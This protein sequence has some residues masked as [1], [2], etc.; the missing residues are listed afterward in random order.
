MG[1]TPGSTGPGA[2]RA[3]DE[4]VGDVVAVRAEIA[5]LQARE[6]E[7]LATAVDLVI[8]RTA[9]RRSEQRRYGNDLALREVCAELGAAMRVSERTV[10]LRMGDAS[11][12]V[13]SFPDTLEAW[14]AG[15]IDHRHV[16]VIR[17]AGATIDDP[18]ARTRYEQLALAAAEIETAGRLRP[19]VRVIADRVDPD[20]SEGRRQ[21]A[22]STRQVRVIDLDDGLA[23]LIADLPAALAYAIL[24]RLTQMGRHMHESPDPIEGAVQCGG[25]GCPAADGCGSESCEADG[26]PGADHE[27][28]TVVRTGPGEKRN[29]STPSDEDPR[30]DDSAEDAGDARDAEDA[31]DA[32][33]AGDASDAGDA[34]DA[35]DAGDAF[36]VE[37]ADAS[38]LANGDGSAGVPGPGLVEDST[39]DEAVADPRTMDQLRADILADLLL[40]AAPTA[41]GTK[42]G[43]AA[44]AAHVQ[45]SVP[46]L[47]AAGRGDEPALLAGYGPIDVETARRLAGGA[48]GWDRVMFHPHTGAP[49]AVDRYRRSAEL[50]RFLRARDERCR[51]PGCRQPV[52]RCDVDHTIDAAHGGGTS[53]CNLAHLC[54]RHHILKHGSEWTVRQLGGGVLEWRSPTGRRYLDKP[55]GTVRFVPDLTFDGDPPPF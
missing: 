47:T 41:H 43:L 15:R 34:G 50:D 37:A 32:G 10:Q 53:E 3:L 2:W 26:C 30:R 6:A 31:G 36:G 39:P 38:P 11:A 5:A 46:V 18:A 14:R 28:A 40:S 9:E 49:L 7:L 17:D 52:W 22:Q 19:L 13:T 35:E 29:A 33:D 54:K 42:T 8:V 51:F 44:I 48:T 25:D 21:R 24:D 55:P 27:D 16:A 23:R 20:G 4:L 12:L 45:V 1:H